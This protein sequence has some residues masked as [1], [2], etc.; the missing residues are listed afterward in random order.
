VKYMVQKWYHDGDTKL[1][2]LPKLDKV[3]CKASGSCREYVHVRRGRR[4]RHQ[5]HQ[6]PAVREDHVVLV[7]RA[8]QDALCPPPPRRLTVGEQMYPG[9]V[10][11]YDGVI[12]HGH[13]TTCFIIRLC[14]T[15]TTI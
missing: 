15:C 3:H 9:L 12:A 10:A 2:R 1:R 13:K 14:V 7:G 5:L 11:D 4:A 6:H 8:F